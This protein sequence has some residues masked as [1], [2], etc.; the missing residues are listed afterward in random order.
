MIAPLPVY[1]RLQPTAGKRSSDFYRVNAYPWLVPL[2]GWCLG[3]FLSQTEVLLPEDVGV[4]LESCVPLWA[5]GLGLSALGA[6][7]RWRL[8]AV[9]TLFLGFGCL[10]F[11]RTENAWPDAP[12]VRS[13]FQGAGVCWDNRTFEDSEGFRWRM[14][15]L[16]TVHMLQE[17]P[18]VW[19]VSAQVEPLT[20][21]SIP[22]GFS[23]RAVFGPQGFSGQ[24]W[25]QQGTPVGSA[26]SDF[27]WKGLFMKIQQAAVHRIDQWSYS[28]ETRGLIKA[29]LVGDRS[30]ISPEIRTGFARL[31]LAHIVSISGFHMALI[32]SFFAFFAKKAG[33]KRGRLFEILGLVAVVGFTAVSGGAPSAVRSAL[34]AFVAVLGRWLHRPQVGLHHLTLVALLLLACFPLWLLDLG[35]QLS[36]VSLAGILLWAPQ[37]IPAWEAAWWTSWAAQMATLPLTVLVFHQFSWVFLFSN[38]VAGPLFELLLGYWIFQGLVEALLFEVFSLASWESVWRDWELKAAY[39]VDQAVALLTQWGNH[40]SSAQEGVFPDT[41]YLVLLVLLAAG[42]A[43][44]VYKEAGRGTRWLVAGAWIPVWIHWVGVARLPPASHCTVYTTRSSWVV[45]F[46]TPDSN[47]AYCTRRQMDNTFFW[48][49]SS[50]GERLRLRGNKATGGRSAVSYTSLKAMVEQLP[51]WDSTRTYQRWVWQTSDWVKKEQL[52]DGS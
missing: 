15:W 4:Y 5:L 14:V 12:E 30:E 24:M 20:P 49:V 52:P 45:E 31:G 40:P 34:M 42:S 18:S 47:W 39:Y 48:E 41:G 7:W 29:L 44:S 10:G 3:G 2:L 33:P 46:N 16:D 51:R 13:L 32:F 37:K 23:A 25:V 27:R 35:F 43:W 36:V 19:Q 22:G 38:A 11:E 8:G 9:A 6:V 17:F 1:R 28:G 26:T 50:A 21:A